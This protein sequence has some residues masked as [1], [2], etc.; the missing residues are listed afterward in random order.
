MYS[1]D[2]FML[3]EPTEEYADQIDEFRVEF[4]DWRNTF[5]GFASLLRM[6]DAKKWIEWCRRQKNPALVDPD[7][8]TA[9]QYLYIRK[10]DNRLVGLIQVRHYFDE[11]LEK[12]GGNIGYSVRPDERRKGI[13][14]LMFRAVLP[15]CRALGLEKVIACCRDGNVG[16]EN[17]I[18]AN[19]GELI[20]TVYEPNRGIWVKRFSIDLE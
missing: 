6:G 16:A 20:N 17:T 15:E 14:R 4:L 13:G 3:I 19:G 12:Y 18:R 9:T 1:S 2:D 7:R 5:S 11:F 8:V 10:S